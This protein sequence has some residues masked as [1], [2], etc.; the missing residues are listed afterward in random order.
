MTDEKLKEMLS[1]IY[2]SINETKGLIDA[3][4]DGLTSYTLR[5]MTIRA[6]GDLY[7]A[8]KKIEELLNEEEGDE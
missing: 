6:G 4:K 5:A 8:K 2:V 3:I 7:M 1:D